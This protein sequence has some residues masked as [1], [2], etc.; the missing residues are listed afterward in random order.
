MVPPRPFRVYLSHTPELDEYPEDRSFADEVRRACGPAP[1]V[2][3]RPEELH[4]ADALVA[5]VGFRHG[6]PD[7]RSGL[8]TTEADFER[9][10]VLGLPRLVFLLGED[11][12]GPARIFADPEH[13]ARQEGFRRQLRAASAVTATVSSPEQLH[14]AVREALSALRAGSPGA[15]RRLSSIPAR[16]PRFTGREDVLQELEH[17][18]TSLLSGP[19][20]IGKSAI[21]VEHAHRV[22]DRL[23]LAW[24]VSCSTPEAVPDA[25]ADLA[26][27]LG[28]DP[29]RGDPVE[30]LRAALTDLRGDW[31][32]VL[33]DVVDPAS[34]T[35]LLGLPGRVLITSRRHDLPGDLVFVPPF[36][37][38]ES[39]RFLRDRASR[40]DDEDARRLA[41]RVGGP[42]LALG[43]A[44]AHLERSGG[45][46][47]DF[48]RRLDAVGRSWPGG[49]SGREVALSTAAALRV[50]VEDLATRDPLAWQVLTLAAWL[51][52]GPVPYSLFTGHLDLLPDPVRGTAPSLAIA[53]A[54]GSL[55]QLGFVEV[56]AGALTVHRHSAAELRDYAQQ[57][58][59][60]PGTWAGTAV[61]VLF[62]AL[63]DD[64][65]A[66]RASRAAWE[67]ALPHVL[68]AC[69]PHRPLHEVSHE[70][71][72]LLAGAA[73]YLTDAGR[74]AEAARV[75]EQRSALLRIH[76]DSRARGRLAVLERRYRSAVDSFGVDSAEAAEAATGYADALRDAGH[77]DTALRLLREV[78]HGDSTA[79]HPA[80]LAAA[81]GLAAL[82]RDGGRP[83]EALS[84]LSS[85][86]DQAVE[87]LGPDDRDALAAQANLAEALFEHGDRGHALSLLERVVRQSR[88]VLGP[89]HPRT[90]LA[91]GSFAAMLVEAGELERARAAHQ[92][93]LRK[94][95]GI[96]GPD[97]P[98]TLTAALN[99]A[100]NL[101]ALGDVDGAVALGRDTLDRSR[102]VL[103]D[104]HPSTLL[105]ANNLADDYRKLG[106]LEEALALDEDTS[107][108]F[109]RTLGDD[110][111]DTAGS[112]HNLALDRELLDRRRR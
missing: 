19:A 54:V 87:V 43:V 53:E 80:R 44:A 83:A 59:R 92:D 49:S 25:L 86:V 112:L 32:V 100:A 104:D 36:D 62:A 63:P 8:S 75:R 35:P 108:R 13:G 31:L 42:P 107:E 21:A 26:T 23:E 78:V 102:E 69:E 41:G 34:V 99:L 101:S 82:L 61:R 105:A 5:V 17:G 27:A 95:R 111:P 89:A 29:G 39:V 70:A 67:R 65:T 56:A 79:T 6:P 46:A 18:R 37:P 12:V 52:P 72:R 11:T 60:R 94:Y 76:V 9:A 7:G 98:D 110:H 103:G 84:L 88:Q 57:R 24:W 51:A 55:R 45:T 77:Q 30:A 22:R 97:H 1:V 3:G 15:A 85:V 91:T 14:T 58:E 10:G 68:A 47:R 20:G 33:D 28:A 90:L 71:G 64:P 66:D 40:V 93:V 106:R 2:S 81:T 4:A 38:V 73:D 74:A 16:N 109:R 50:V 48:L 96:L